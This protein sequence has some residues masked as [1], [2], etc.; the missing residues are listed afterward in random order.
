MA[1]KVD[2]P[3]VEVLQTLQPFVELD[4]DSLKSLAERVSIQGAPSS[5]RLVELGSNEPV[6]LF[7]LDGEIELNAADGNS[8]RINADSPTAKQPLCQLRPT[9]YE[10]TATTKV[11]YLRIE[12][13][14]IDEYQPLE[15]HSSYL[16]SSGIDNYSVIESMLDPEN[17]LEELLIAQIVDALFEGRLV[18]P[19]LNAVAQKVGR[20]M[21]NAESD[22]RKLT[23]A[24]MLDPSLAA[25]AIKAVNKNLA[26]HTSL[27]KTCD[28]AVE[29]L[30]LER[31]TSLAVNCALRE[32]MRS[33]RPEIADRM[34]V[35]WE[36]SL[37]VSAISEVLAQQSERFDP[38]LAALAGLL[39]RI[40]EAA[41]LG[42]ADQ[43]DPP[44]ATEQL[45]SVILR[46]TRQISMDLLS[47]WNHAPELLTVAS[48]SGHMERN[49]R[50]EP[51]YAD[52]VLV[53]ERHADI[54]RNDLQATPLDKMPAFQRLGLGNM[55]PSFS[56][57]IVQAA[58]EVMQE[59]ND[60]LAA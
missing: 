47:M 59:A 3:S 25:K 46:N 2:H 31:V 36:R 14:L 18:V 40:G 28:E 49:N 12:N 33:P 48:E 53:A 50:Y 16:K 7:L 39:H 5:T 29:R 1:K 30:G 6:S 10:C 21:L 54:G 58:S 34:Q 52:I 9:R 17:E 27:V 26:P 45:D 22:P 44:M 35:W 19:S 11:L 41:I 20:A 43:L 42:Y 32:T 55:S 60:I 51:D 8:F 4:T 13:D 38:K 15:N 24:L 57:T 37:R 56:M 23:R